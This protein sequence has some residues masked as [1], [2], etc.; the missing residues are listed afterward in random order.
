MFTDSAIDAVFKFSSGLPRLINR[1]CSGSLI[2]AAQ[3]R[4][5][6]IDDHMVKLIVETE[7]SGGVTDEL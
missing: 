1:A 2:Y 4:K 7:L 6:L 5:Q 3:Q